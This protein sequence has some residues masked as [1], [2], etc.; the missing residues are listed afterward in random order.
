MVG[1]E[2]DVALGEPFVLIAGLPGA[3]KTSVARGVAQAFSPSIHLQVDKLREMAAR[4]HIATDEAQGWS[5]E[6]AAQ[7]E[8]ESQ[9]AL[10]LAQVYRRQRRIVVIDDVAMPPIFHRC[11]AGQASLRKILLMPSLAALEHRLRGRGGVY[12]ALFLQIIEALHGM[13]ASLDHSGWMV[14]DSSEWSVERTVEGVLDALSM[15]S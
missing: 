10:A 8:L 5:D 3:G 2:A 9:A 6:L 4:G 11:Y 15:P 1:G 12:D 14:L 7:F 13:L